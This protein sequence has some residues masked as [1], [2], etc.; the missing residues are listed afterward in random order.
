MR[1]NIF[2]VTLGYYKISQ[3][4]SSNFDKNTTFRAKAQSTSTVEMSAAVDVLMSSSRSQGDSVPGHVTAQID[5]SRIVLQFLKVL[6]TLPSSTNGMNVLCTHSVR[7]P[8]F[9]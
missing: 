3:P 4:Y 5:D 1:M 8:T 6:L 9:K 7:E 2:F